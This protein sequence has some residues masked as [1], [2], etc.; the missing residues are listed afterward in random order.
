MSEW[1]A[2]AALVLLALAFMTTV[3][4][5]NPVTSASP[6]GAPG[7]AP[8]TVPALSNNAA[9]A[10]APANGAGTAGAPGNNAGP[11]GAPSNEA[12]TAGAPPNS[13]GTAGAPRSTGPASV[14]GVVVPQAPANNPVG[15]L[16]PVSP[17]TPGSSIGTTAA[18]SVT[19]G[20]VGAPSSSIGS[21]EA[22]NGPPNG[23]PDA[24][25]PH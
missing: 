19:I 21:V 14:G 10:A 25:Q 8:A 13:V 1:K 7:N 15:V 22:T 24:R 11:A 23:R 17:I 4:A 2:V 18:P 20:S 3:H 6:P 16:P 9:T 5:A 12:G